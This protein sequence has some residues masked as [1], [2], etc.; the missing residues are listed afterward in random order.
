MYG[1]ALVFKDQNY[2]IYH[3]S[4]D[5]EYVLW[6]NTN[7][8]PFGLTP[9]SGSISPFK[10]RG[11]ERH[12]D[13]ALFNKYKSEAMVTVG[14]DVYVIRSFQKWTNSSMNVTKE[15]MIPNFG[16]DGTKV[17]AATD[18]DLNGDKIMLISDQNY[19]FVEWSQLRCEQKPIKEYFKCEESADSLMTTNTTVMTSSGEPKSDSSGGSKTLL[20]IVFVGFVVL[21][22]VLILS[23]GLFCFI[24]KRKSTSKVMP[25]ALSLNSKQ[26]IT[27]STT[28]PSAQ[29]RGGKEYSTFSGAFGPNSQLK[30]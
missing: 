10:A 28:Q 13:S 3:Y 24:S 29:S 4:R 21:I 26:S 18:F 20:I 14:S 22:A 23:I 12:I 7:G 16:F 17:G 1:L 30:T 8:L 6:N 5:L 9:G 25:S 11:D 2:Y 15:K 27:R 19:C